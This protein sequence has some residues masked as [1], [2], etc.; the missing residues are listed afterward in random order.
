[1]AVL[2][3]NPNGPQ[4]QTFDKGTGAYKVEFPPIAGVLSAI[5]QQR[6][7]DAERKQKQVDEI[8]GGIAKGVGGVAQ[9]YQNQNDTSAL[10]DYMQHGAAGNPVGQDEAF[11]RM[12]PRA[13]EM[14]LNWQ[15]HNGPAQGP[16]QFYQAPDGSW[17]VGDATGHAGVKNVSSHSGT[18]QPGQPPAGK[19]AVQDENG[20]TIYVTANDAASI[21]QANKD[22][23]TQGQNLKDVTEP[24]RTQYYTKD[25]KK[26]DYSDETGRVGTKEAEQH[27]DDVVAVLPDKRVMPYDEFQK[28]QE[29]AAE[30]GP[31]T[32]PYYH[33][34]EGA[35]SSQAPAAVGAYGPPANTR[36][37]V[38]GVPA[39]WDGHAWRR[40]EPS[41]AQNAFGGEANA[42]RDDYRAGRIS[43]EEA[44][45]RLAAIGIY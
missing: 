41:G 21:G 14:A 38:N 20:N 3:S 43:R 30:K 5:L 35:V 34:P 33:I 12:S 10:N 2:W 40:L 4:G 25:Y 18:N 32:K 9:G 7:A 44:K 39:Y 11:Q 22:Y 6:Q 13:R 31:G 15:Y 24:Y 8:I 27:S 1:M 28:F 29:K 16:P 45:Q 26:S 42:I 37:T 17:V 19:V 36:G 23:Q